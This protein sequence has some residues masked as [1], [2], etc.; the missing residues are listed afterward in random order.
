MNNELFDKAWNVYLEY[1]Q[2]SMKG[3]ESAEGADRL[4]KA[5]NAWMGMVTEISQAGLA[6]D[7]N[8]YSTIKQEE[9]G[10]FD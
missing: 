1:L 8:A 6:D 5:K 7:W 3:D 9:L 4:E 2:E 10:I